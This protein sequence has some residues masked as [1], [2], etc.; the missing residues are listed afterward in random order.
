M[1]PLN[2]GFPERGNWLSCFL[3]TTPLHK[4]LLGSGRGKVYYIMTVTKG[5]GGLAVLPGCHQLLCC[6]IYLTP[7][8]Y[9]WNFTRALKERGVSLLIV[10]MTTAEAPRR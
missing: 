3:T 9:G 8:L 7:V 5:A 2:S 4:H 1:Q 10:V 6:S